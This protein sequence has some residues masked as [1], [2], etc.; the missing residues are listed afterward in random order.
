MAR[1]LALRYLVGSPSFKTCKEEET[2]YKFVQE[3]NLDFLRMTFGKREL[4]QKTT[5][6]QSVTFTKSSLD[7]FLY[8]CLYQKTL[9]TNM[10]VYCTSFKDTYM[11][12]EIQ[13]FIEC[14]NVFT[15]KE[16]LKF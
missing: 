3:N 15:K 10:Q 5:G 12:G 2:T 8:V 11:I 6:S 4:E 7:Q 16:S 1:Y 13:A 14:I 9:V